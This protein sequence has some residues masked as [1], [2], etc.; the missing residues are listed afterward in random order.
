MEAQSK[1]I[2]I[3]IGIVV[4]FSVIAVLYPEASDAGDSLSDESMCGEAGCFFNDS[5]TIE[6]TSSNVTAGDTTVCATGYG[7]NGF[8]LAGL[9]AGGG[10]VFLVL[11]AGLIYFIIKRK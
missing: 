11:A 6:C 10:V 2:G 5:R 8:P 1:Y 3:F 7:A 4:L 9:F